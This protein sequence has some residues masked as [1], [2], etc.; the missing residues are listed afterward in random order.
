MNLEKLLREL[1]LMKNQPSHRFYAALV[2]V[3]LVLLRRSFLLAVGAL[4]SW[5]GLR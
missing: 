1:R 2:M 5:H 3:L 4:F